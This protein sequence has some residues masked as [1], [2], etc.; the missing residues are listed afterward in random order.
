MIRKNQP[1]K[2]ARYGMVIDLDRCTGCGACMIACAVE[3]NVPAANPAA[4]GRTGLTWMR[5]F[6]L[7]SEGQRAFV[8]VMCQQ[9][10][11]ETPCAS[12]CPQQAVELDAATGV[13]GQVPA[14]CLG[15]RYCMAACPYHARY[16]NWWDP[17][18][19]PGMEAALNPDVAPRMRGVVEKCNFCH[20]RWHAAKEKAAAAGQREIQ[21]GDYVP[22]CAEACPTA[23]IVFGDLNDPENEAARASRSPDAFRLLESLGTGSKVYYRSRRPWLRAAA[24]RGP[25]DPSHG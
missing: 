16:F 18:W 9:C 5:V 4:T 14:R 23:A 12:V 20:G 21:A 11:H 6:P 15:C 2:P 24:T 22:A 10:E 8:P 3:N 1:A 19:P 13:V 25:E 7:E 17:A